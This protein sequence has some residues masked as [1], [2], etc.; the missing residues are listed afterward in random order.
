MM[1]AWFYH[2]TST[3]NKPQQLLK[4]ILGLASLL[5]IL[6]IFLTPPWW[7]HDESG[8]FQVAW[9]I[10]NHNAWPAVEQYDDNM[11]LKMARSLDKFGFYKYNNY[12]L[13]LNSGTPPW[14]QSPQAQDPPFYYFLASLPLRFLKSTDL[15]FQ[16]LVLRL[17][18]LAFLLTTL[19]VSWQ[20]GEEIFGAGHPFQIMTTALLGFLPG[21]VNEMTAVSDIPPAVL[22]FSIFL[23]SCVRLLRRGFSWKEFFI[24]IISSA[25]A[26]ATSS[27]V[28][29]SI[30]LLLIILLLFMIFNNRL[31]W[32]PWVLMGLSVVLIPFLVLQWG[33]A[34]FWQVLKPA[35]PFSREYSAQAPLGQQV[36]QVSY[37]NV[38]QERLPADILK[39]LRSKNLT[40][41]YWAWAS[42][43]MTVIAPYISFE[44]DLN[45]KYSKFTS[46]A[47]TTQPQFFTEL[48]EVPSDCGRALLIF[49]P[50]LQQPAGQNANIFWDGIVLAAGDR[51]KEIPRFT[52]DSANSGSWNGSSFTN[53]VRNGS[54]ETAWLRFTPWFLEFGLKKV[55]AYIS[56]STMTT[57]QDWQGSSFYFRRTAVML[58]ESFWGKLGPSY[59]PLLGSP[60]VYQV[61]QVIFWLGLAGYL[62]FTLLNYK[63]VDQRVVLILILAILVLWMQTWLRGAFTLDDQVPLVIPWARYALPAFVPTVLL[64]CTG[65]YTLLNFLDRHLARFGISI[66]WPLTIAFLSALDL[67]AALTLVNF[68][69]L[70]TDWPY[71]VLFFFLI[72]SAT[73]ILILLQK[74]NYLHNRSES[75]P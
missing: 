10:A 25:A 70:Q 71:L 17:L 30:A 38:L 2:L 57:L 60:Y 1:R 42:K 31:K 72:L 36:L 69:Y 67:M 62:I 8:H 46:L 7:H 35:E 48:V 3:F 56:A 53:L 41:G 15:A 66:L 6:F 28:W 73:I 61:L 22:L 37:D 39:P 5:G 21:F 27:L 23:L 24:L 74:S 50:S 40:L 65:W 11:R 12:K 59:I 52:D 33:D 45:N 20:I 44:S 14:I 18:A 16:D 68:F 26:M 43:P 32:V 9:F 51:G 19:W 54:A 49:S 47:L 63:Q 4:L 29:I 34:R 55:S 58:N 13:D 64:L 75:K